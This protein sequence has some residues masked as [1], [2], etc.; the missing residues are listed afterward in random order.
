MAALVEPGGGTERTTIGVG[1]KLAV[2]ALWPIALLVDALHAV[3]RFVVTAFRGRTVRLDETREPLRRATIPPAPAGRTHGRAACVPATPL[4]SPP[5]PE[6]GSSRGS[7]AAAG[8]ANDGGDPDPAGSRFWLDEIGFVMLSLS[9]ELRRLAVPLPRD[10]APGRLAGLRVTALSADHPRGV[11]YE[12]Y[13]PTATMLAGRVCEALLAPA[14]PWDAAVSSRRIRGRRHPEN[15]GSLRLD[16]GGQQRLFRHVEQGRFHAERPG[17]PVQR[18]AR[19]APSV[20]DDSPT[21][22]NRRMEDKP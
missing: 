8:P 16:W 19:R 17:C 5:A 1:R 11:R 4:P 15:V 9:G 14:S 3:W 10:L 6:R 21:E 20:D 12:W 2:L 22:P 7:A 18:R 13:A